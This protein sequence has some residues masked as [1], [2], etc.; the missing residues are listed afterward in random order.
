MTKNADIDKYKYSGYGIG[1]D[2]H[3]SF[4]FPDTGLEQ[5]E[6]IFGVDMTSSTE[7]DSYCS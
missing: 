7:I 1:F 4:S 6:I 5:N 2:R 3:K